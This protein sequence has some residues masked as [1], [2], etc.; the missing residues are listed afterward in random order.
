MYYSLAFAGGAFA[1]RSRSRDWHESAST[2]RARTNLVLSPAEK[3]VCGQGAIPAGRTRGAKR[4]GSANLRA[5]AGLRWVVPSEHTPAHVPR[6]RE[7]S[8][9]R[10][11]QENEYVEDQERTGRKA[12]GEKSRRLRAAD[13]ERLRAGMPVQYDLHQIKLS[14]PSPLHLPLVRAAS[15]KVVYEAERVI[16]A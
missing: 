2:E 1:G 16:L 13:T 14:A 12:E 9:H 11:N 5:R 4:F 15:V 3:S 6:C 10:E 8:D 7:R